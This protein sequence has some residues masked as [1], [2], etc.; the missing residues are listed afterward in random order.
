MEVYGNDSVLIPPAPHIVRS[1]Y[2]LNIIKHKLIHIVVISLVQVA[3][4]S[5]IYITFLQK[6]FAGGNKQQKREFV[7][8]NV[9]FMVGNWLYERPMVAF[10][11]NCSLVFFFNIVP[12]QVNNSN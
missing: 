2:L 3:V 10:K 8:V 6:L 12:L 11:Y 9:R 4:I 1:K 7:F 5:L